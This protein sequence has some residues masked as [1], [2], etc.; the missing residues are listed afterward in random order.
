MG[1]SEGWP[2]T[3]ILGWSS[4]HVRTVFKVWL[5]YDDNLLDNLLPRRVQYVL[6]IFNDKFKYSII[7][8]CSAFGQTSI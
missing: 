8:V 7:V 2:I 4:I 6:K 5:K 1:Q 3:K